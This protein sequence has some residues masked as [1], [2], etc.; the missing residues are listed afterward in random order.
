MD[1]DQEEIPTAPAWV[2]VVLVLI[3]LISFWCQ[4]TVTEERF[5]P[6]LNVISRYYKISDDVAGATLMAGGASAPEL[7]SSFVALFI[8]HSSLGLGTIVGSEIFNQLIICAGAVMATQKGR[9]VLNP[10]ILIREVFFYFLSIVALYIAIRDTEHD[11]D[12]PEGPK[13]VF[14]NFWDAAIL[15]APYIFY[16][17]VCGN[18]DNLVAWIKGKPL[19]EAKILE[20]EKNSYGTLKQSIRFGDDMKFLHS[21]ST[22]S[23]E[24]DG[25]FER[26]HLETTVSGQPS[27]HADFTRS[28]RPQTQGFNGV[29]LIHTLTQRASNILNETEGLLAFHFV[30]HESRPSDDHGLLDIESDPESFS[31][32]LWQR[33]YF[34][35]Y[36]RFSR[37]AWQLKWFTIENGRASS[38]PNRAHAELHRNY[39]PKFQEIGIDEKRLIIRIINPNP[40][41]RDYFLMAP[42][43]TIFQAVVDKLEDLMEGDMS[44]GAGESEHVSDYDGHVEEKLTQFPE[45]ATFFTLVFFFFLYPIRFLM[46]WT[47]PDVRLSDKHGDPSVS[48]NVALLAC[49]SCLVW[50]VVGSY[51]MVASLE[52]L[53]AYMDIPDA[54][55]GVTVSAAGTSLPNYVASKVAAEAGFGNMAVSNA[56]GSNT[57]NIMVGLGLPWLVYTSAGTGFKPYH[58]LRDE[59]I[60]E[61]IVILFAV[62]LVFVVLVFPNNFVIERWHGYLFILMYVAYIAYEIAQVY[63]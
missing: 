15:F 45:D 26:L 57:F 29:P 36:A 37:H 46:Q 52:N 14:V 40:E 1:N 12:D 44:V 62:L 25:N 4:A 19:K 35:S 58:G 5:V 53:A 28:V 49:F 3:A 54:I 13:H 21:Q 8:T 17:L 59:G 61:N 34:Y 16:V 43:K 11:P 38:V 56:F 33:S 6:A 18:M 30:E 42:S 55:I 23:R 7:F 27:C 48:I 32:F 10:E 20:A 9:L 51:A 50:L 60:T 24:P 31:C 63:M 2:W 39:Y 47:I 41:H 22:I